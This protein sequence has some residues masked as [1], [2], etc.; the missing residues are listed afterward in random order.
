MLTTALLLLAAAGTVALR[1][2]WDARE[3]AQL[4]LT[5]AGW[6]AI[7]AALAV[8][9]VRDG[10]WGLAMGTLPVTL[11]AFG[12]LLR[13][14]IASTAPTRAARIA[15]TEPSVRLHAADWRDV[16]RRVAIFLIAV[17]VAGAV[18][19]LFGLALAAAARASGAV[20]ADTITTALFVTPLVWSVF[21][22][23]LLLQPRA[24]PMLRP[25]LAI[26]AVSGATFWLLG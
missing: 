14:A 12:F 17:P 11:V 2:A 7:G 21:G 1:L 22:V 15:E 6:G 26:G 20:E 18:S 9:V 23:V 5:L 24:A 25:L 19:L 4:R 13:E 10:A 16:G 3:P 8:L